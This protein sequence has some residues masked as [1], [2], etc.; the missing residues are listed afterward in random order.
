MVNELGFDPELLKQPPEV[1]QRW[2]DDRKIAHKRLEEAS[3]KIMK[4]IR[5][6]SGSEVVHVVGPTGVGKTTLMEHAV[7][8]LIRRA[9]PELKKDPGFI[10]TAFI[11]CQSP[12]LG[13]YDW[14]EHFIRV[15]LALNEVLI[16]RKIYIPDAGPVP[17]EVKALVK[18]RVG[19]LRALRRGA[20]SAI[21]NRKLHAFFAD[22]AQFILKGSSGERVSSQA[23]AA[24]SIA[25]ESTLHVL[26][27]HY[28]LLEMMNLNGQLGRRSRTVHFTRY[29][30]DR[31]EDRVEFA[32]V[33]NTLQA[34][35]PLPQP[36]RLEGHLDFAFERTVGC[37][38]RLKNW[39]S[40]CLDTALTNKC[41]TVTYEIFKEEADSISVCR[42]TALETSEGEGKLKEQDDENAENDLRNLLKEGV[43]LTAPTGGMDFTVGSS[44]APT[45]EVKGETAKPK[46]QGSQKIETK[47]RRY[48][49]GA[50]NVAS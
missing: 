26:L 47:P 29:Y 41:K 15:L 20:E 4:T 1:R 24:R 16:D 27:G 18:E 5:A 9:M 3:A 7:S 12:T 23:D 22:E 40:R 30:I 34:K 42:Q 49:T 11:T 33:L 13:V 10:P 45:P 25:S 36:T 44:V 6:P 21:R 2:F 35:L 43:R 38:G 50:K 14:T 31:A 17:D 32:K 19:K 39:F 28:D 46:K 8:A 37:V 48:T